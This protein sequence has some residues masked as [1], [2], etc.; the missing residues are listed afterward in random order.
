MDCRLIKLDAMESLTRYYERCLVP[1]RRFGH[2]IACKVHAG[3]GPGS[4]AREIRQLISK[5]LTSH[6]LNPAGQ[7]NANSMNFNTHLGG[8]SSILMAI[9]PTSFIIA[10]SPPCNP[11]RLSMLAKFCKLPHM[12]AR[13]I[14]LKSNYR[15]GLISMAMIPG[16]EHLF[17]SPL[18]TTGIG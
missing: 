9:Q 10:L 7:T 3:I 15:E 13:R 16:N 14:V 1:F 4:S 11:I 6:G 12:S 18:R 8:D 17:K 2:E 5:T